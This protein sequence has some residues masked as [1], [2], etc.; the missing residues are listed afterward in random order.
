M[1]ATINDLSP[2]ADDILYVEFVG[3]TGDLGY[4]NAMQV[5]STTTVL[6][7]DYN[8]NGVVDAADYVLWRDNPSAFGG[9]PA[10]YDTWRA[11]FGRPPGAG[12]AL[13]SGGAHAAVPEPISLLLA[14]SSAIALYSCQRR[15]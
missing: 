2:Q 10:G 12:S 6:A 8:S 5:E 11:N 4:L 14:L 7:G 9:E 15:R 3:S 13:E 1:V